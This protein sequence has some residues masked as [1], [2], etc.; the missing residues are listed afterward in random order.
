MVTQR[1][2]AAALRASEDCA[3]LYVEQNTTDLAVARIAAGIGIAERTFYRHF[4]RKRDTI[5]PLL[6][7]ASTVTAAS[8]RQSV[9]LPIQQALGQAFRDAFGGE[10]E[11]Q[12]RKLYPLIFRDSGMRA[13]LLQ[14]V[15]DGETVVRPAIA[16]RLDVPADSIQARTAASIFVSAVLISLE[17]MVQSGT[18]PFQTFQT[19]LTA[20]TENPLRPTMKGRTT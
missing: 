9:D 10:R 4:P 3:R 1:Q 8:I 15:H 12:T 6:D 7:L 16:E 2:A 5:R 14:A 11:E 17:V 18:D 13:V 20:A 19:V